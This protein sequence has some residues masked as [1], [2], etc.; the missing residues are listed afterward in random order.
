MKRLLVIINPI[1]GISSKKSVVNAITSNIDM[2]K[3]DVMMH[4]TQYPGHATVLA[5]EAVKN[6][7]DV[8]VAV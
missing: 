2:K 4:F 6:K 7:V 5:E 8:V 1:S 3:F